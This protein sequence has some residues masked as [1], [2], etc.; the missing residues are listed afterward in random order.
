MPDVHYTYVAVGGGLTIHFAEWA[1]LHAKF[2][3]HV[4]TNFGPIEAPSEYGLAAGY[5]LRFSGGIDFL[6]WKGLRVG[7]QGFYEHFAIQFGYDRNNE[8]KIADTASDEYYGG[9]LIL[10]YVY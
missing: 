6:V 9:M 5:G 1:W 10:G 2:V 7:A 8:A 4:I 3:Y